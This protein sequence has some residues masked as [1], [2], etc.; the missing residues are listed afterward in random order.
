MTFP[1]DKIKNALNF[2]L[3]NEMNAYQRIGFRQ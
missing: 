2:D 1:I 3:K